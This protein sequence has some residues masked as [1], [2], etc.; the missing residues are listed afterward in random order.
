MVWAYGVAQTI[1]I[2]GVKRETLDGCG[3]GLVRLLRYILRNEVHRLTNRPIHIR[4]VC[5]LIRGIVGSLHSTSTDVVLHGYTRT[6]RDK[7]MPRAQPQAHQLTQQ[8]KNQHTH[9]HKHTHQHTHT[10]HREKERE[11]Q[12][13]RERGRES[14]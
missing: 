10:T 12:K 7:G 6:H 3:S 13:Q 4:V 14:E 1:K 2:N 9:T 11:R 5:H 8:N